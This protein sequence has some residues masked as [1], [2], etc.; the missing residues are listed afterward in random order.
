MAPEM[1][2][3]DSWWPGDFSVLSFDY[4]DPASQAYVQ[5]PAVL[6]AK[7]NIWQIGMLILCAIRLELELLETQ[8]RNPPPGYSVPLHQIMAFQP[9]HASR[10]MKMRLDD[11][12]SKRYS[13]QLLTLVN[14]CLAVDPGARISP[15]NLLQE[16]QLKMVGRDGGMM[17]ATGKFPWN[18]PQAIRMK[19]EDKYKIGKKPFR[20]RKLKYM[21]VLVLC[22]DGG[23][24]NHVSFRNR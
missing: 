5:V 15:Q 13:R 17:T 3:D 24:V 22:L 18:H 14:K 9:P 21:A 23:G 16:V 1:S 8:W 6:S 11:D 20:P 19:L 7:T 2:Y 10:P 12:E 4:W